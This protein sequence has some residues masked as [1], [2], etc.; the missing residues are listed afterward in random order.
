MTVHLMTALPKLFS[1]YHPDAQ[2][3][4]HLLKLVQM[5][6]F[7]SFIALNK[8]N[9]LVQLLDEVANVFMRFNYTEMSTLSTA[10]ET[11]RVMRTHALVAQQTTLRLG[12]ICE[13]VQQ[14]FWDVCGEAQEITTAVLDRDAL[15]R[16]T[17]AIVRLELILRHLDMP[18]LFQSNP[19]GIPTYKLVDFILQRTHLNQPNECRLLETAFHLLYRGVL[20]S[21][22]GI[23]AAEMP[24]DEQLDRHTQ[25]C[26]VLLM[27]AE[28]CMSLDR[29]TMETI[30][31]LQ[32]RAFII[33]CQVYWLM[34]E[35]VNMVPNH[36][37]QWPSEELE[38]K[39]VEFVQYTLKQS[40]DQSEHRTLLEMI[41]SFARCIIYNVFSP[42]HAVCTLANYGHFGAVYDE[43]QRTMVERTQ[44]FYQTDMATTIIS[45]SLS[46]SFMLVLG[47]STKQF[48]MTL[49][50][51][52]MLFG[53]L[54]AYAGQPSV[55]VEGIRFVVEKMEHYQQL[56]E[57][58]SRLEMLRYFRI[59]SILAKNMAPSDAEHV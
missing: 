28:Q 7:D 59:L 19:H 15:E 5:L 30:G 27:H 41:G 12:E 38:R 52:R 48:E 57:K 14:A 42:T 33:L 40:A 21:F 17:M 46:Q 51:A 9:A 58:N 37:R 25:L 50:L 45:G 34:S 11:L 16:L 3:V 43:I 35:M 1:K 13:T 53:F 55:H 54:G 2:H 10:M 47:Q 32:Q 18:I 49:S 24:S 26:N 23:Q 44:T 36:L 31:Q 56:G 20:W 29:E 39:C 6:D 8:T 22:K 4:I